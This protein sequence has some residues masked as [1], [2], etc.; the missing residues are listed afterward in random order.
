MESPGN[1][2]TVVANDMRECRPAVCRLAVG[3]L[4]LWSITAIPTAL[5]YTP[6]SE[7]SMEMTAP[8]KPFRLTTGSDRQ[9]LE[10]FDRAEELLAAGRVQAALEQFGVVAKL[11]DEPLRSRALLKFGFAAS[12]LDNPDARAALIQAAQTSAPDPEGGEIRG[13]ARHLIESSTREELLTAPPKISSKFW[14]ARRVRSSASIWDQ[15]NEVEVLSR[16]DRVSLAVRRYRDLLASYP[17]H[18]VV[19]NNLASLLARGA[20]PAEAE[21]LV[22]RAFHSAGAEKYVEYLYDTLGYALLKQGHA[23]ESIEHFRR[24]LSMRETP[25]RDLHMAMALET[26]GQPD[27]AEQFRARASALDTTGQLAGVE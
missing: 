27:E 14:P 11:A 13:F 8:E 25:E 19:L 4:C 7:N 16:K 2:C 3:S 18:P 6:V 12:I 26:I 10:T 15:I 21:S 17:D 23:A 24:A 9:L 5:A 22:R 20:D 1:Y